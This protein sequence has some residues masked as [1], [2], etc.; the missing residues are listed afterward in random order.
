MCRRYR[1]PPIFFG[2]KFYVEKFGCACLRWVMRSIIL[3]GSECRQ[4]EGQY[5]HFEVSI[6][7]ET[8]EFIEWFLIV[9]TGGPRQSSVKWRVRLARVGELMANVGSMAELMGA[10]GSSYRSRPLLALQQ[11]LQYSTV[12]TIT[13]TTATTTTTAMESMGFIFCGWA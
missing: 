2:S 7:Y 11:Q 1:A 9:W 6:V 3:Y 13:T 8:N 12:S 4:K 5:T 10:A